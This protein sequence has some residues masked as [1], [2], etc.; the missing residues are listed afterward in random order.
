[1]PQVRV[2]TSIEPPDIDSLLK[3]VSKETS[4]LVGKNEQ[5]V[6]ASVEPNV[7]LS[8]SG[9]TEPCCYVE[10]KNIGEL[11]P[12]KITEGLCKLI[13]E[14]TGIPGDRIFVRCENIHGSN[15]GHNSIMFG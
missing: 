8:F 3:A 13:T 10:V 14:K 9:N 12:Q 6:M 1:M 4:A 7:S 15:W 11:N 5:W 2:V